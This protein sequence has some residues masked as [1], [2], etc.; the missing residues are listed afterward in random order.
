MGCSDN[1]KQ[2]LM[3]ATG[4]LLGALLSSAAEL[5]AGV[6]VED[7]GLVLLPNGTD[8]KSKVDT[9]VITSNLA[10]C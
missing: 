7:Q 3:D 2:A 5:L 1:T 6:L 10:Y 9:M 4:D 8:P